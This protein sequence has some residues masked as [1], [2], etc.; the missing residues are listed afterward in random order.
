MLK[1][2]FNDK[3][4]ALGINSTEK[5]GIVDEISTFFASVYQ[6][7][8]KSVFDALWTREQKGSTG[9][10]KGLAIP[11]AR[12]KGVDSIKIAVFYSKEGCTFDSH[13][14]LPTHLFFVAIIDEDI[15]PQKQLEML[16]MI[17]ETSEK[18]DLVD[19][20]KHVSSSAQLRETILNCFIDIQ[21]L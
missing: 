1:D 16:K 13:D 11:H 14:K 21:N 17:V 20:L 10:G 5:H 19:I 3:A 6:L 7:D 9:L 12:L 4:F 2:I 15:K 8:K 18:K